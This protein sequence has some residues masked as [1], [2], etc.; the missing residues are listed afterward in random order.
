[1]ATVDIGVGGWELDT[2]GMSPQVKAAALC[3]KDALNEVMKVLENPP[4]DA[5]TIFDIII[6]GAAAFMAGVSAYSPGGQDVVVQRFTEH[7]KEALALAQEF[8]ERE[9]S[10]YQSME[11]H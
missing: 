9:T 6:Q 11:R 5:T 7:Y 2:R 8:I 3:Y 1:M 10:Q 4:A